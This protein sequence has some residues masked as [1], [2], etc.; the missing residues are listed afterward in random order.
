MCLNRKVKRIT[1]HAEDRFRE[2]ITGTIESRNK[3]IET[4]NEAID[5]GFILFTRTNDKGVKQ[6]IIYSERVGISAVIERKKVVTVVDGLWDRGACNDVK[7]Q[8]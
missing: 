6:E 8:A 5:S 1:D 4:V 2:R 7:A 3:M